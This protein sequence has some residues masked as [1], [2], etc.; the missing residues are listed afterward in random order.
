[1]QAYSQTKHYGDVVVK[2]NFLPKSLYSE[3]SSMI[4]SSGV[5]WHYHSNAT[6]ESNTVENDEY[7]VHPSFRVLDDGKE[8]IS[9]SFNTVR[10]ILYFIEDK[11]QF[12]LE[13]ILR[14]NFT[15]VTQRNRKSITPYH[16]DTPKPHYVG[17]LYFSTCNGPTMIQDKKVDC[18]E[19]RF[20]FFDGRYEHAAV[21]QTDIYARINIVFNLFGNYN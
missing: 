3:V 1:M 16:I 6:N 5:H 11:L 18:I 10:P 12:N 14:V 19:N 20:V 7:F 2:D 15:L 21:H 8:V 13:K 9:P 17:I 4:H